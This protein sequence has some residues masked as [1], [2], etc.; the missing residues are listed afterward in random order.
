MAAIITDALRKNIANTFL[1]E[2]NT[3]GDSHEFYIGIGKSDAYPNNDTL[4]NPTATYRTELEARNNMQSVKKVTNASFVIPRNNWSSGTIYPAFS[5][6]TVDIDDNKYYVLTEDNE[7]YICLQKGRDATGAANPSIVKP[8]YTTAG[9]SDVQSFET[10]D[11]YRW[12]FLYALSATKSSAFLSAGWMPIEVIQGAGGDG[13]QVQ[14]KGIQDAATAGQIVG[15]EVVSG[16]TGYSSAPT[17][18]I[19][20]NGQNAVATATISGGTVVKVEM[21]NES[22]GMGSAYNYASASVSGGSPTTA[23]ALRPIIGPINGIGANAL[24]DLKVKSLMF[25]TKPSGEE[26]GDFITDIEIP[27]RQITLIKNPEIYD[28]DAIYSNTTGRALKY[29]K[30]N[31]TSHGIASGDRVTGQSS[32]AIAFVNDI[33]SSRVYYHQNENSG[34]SLFTDGENIEDSSGTTALVDS[35]QKFSVLDPYSGEVLYIENR[36][37]ITRSAVQTEDIKIVITV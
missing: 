17:V 21:N 15:I 3:S 32:G 36:A 5:D 16:G 8:S 23:A 31:L 18:T 25:N 9:V 20:G 30:M 19:N 12:K 35:A 26:N 37:K 10:S 6:T 24:D 1:T 7:V 34:F 29:L 2:V 28:S 22:A 4:V 33:D 27:F 13:F 14:Q 11:G